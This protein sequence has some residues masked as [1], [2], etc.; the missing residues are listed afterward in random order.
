V[1][2]VALCLPQRK[3][4][5]L[6]LIR[7]SRMTCRRPEPAQRNQP[8][9]PP[10]RVARPAPVTSTPMPALGAA[11]A[12]NG[13]AVHLRFSHAQIAVDQPLG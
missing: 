7:W 11:E 5:P 10:R 3:L 8:R 2:A 1:L 9:R 12:L 13:R 4:Q 6:F